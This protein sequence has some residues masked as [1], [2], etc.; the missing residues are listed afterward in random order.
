MWPG[1]EVAT[2]KVTDGI[3]LNVDTATKFINMPS[4]LDKVDDLR[5]KRYS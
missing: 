3:F 2:K 5:K 4:I 1:Y